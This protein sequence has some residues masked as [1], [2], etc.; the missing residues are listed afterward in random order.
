MINAFYLRIGDFSLSAD[1]IEK[2]MESLPPSVRTKLDKISNLANRNRSALGEILSRFAIQKIKGVKASDQVVEIGSNGK[3]YLA[4]RPE[5]C[6][7]ISHSGEYIVCAVGDENLGIDVERIRD[8]DLRVA[9]R[10]FS[11]PE[12]DDLRSFKD[13]DRRNYFFLLWTIKE[14]YLKALGRGLTKSLGSFTVSRGEGRF[15]LTGEDTAL[16]YSVY[17][18]TLPG[19]YYMSICYEH[20]GEDIVL[21]EVTIDEIIQLFSGIEHN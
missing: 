1:S 17:N 9:E 10:Y 20:P 13:D 3:P 4:N 16:D 15:Y 6:Y 8:F 5:I 21:K 11:K 7:N 2:L 14:S 19:G 12:L 18:C